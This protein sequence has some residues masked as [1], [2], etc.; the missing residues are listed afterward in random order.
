MP[1]HHGYRYRSTL[2]EIHRIGS[3]IGL[4]DRRR[5]RNFAQA[6]Q[7]QLTLNLSAPEES[8]YPAVSPEL[9]ATWGIGVVEKVTGRQSSCRSNHSADDDSFQSRG[10]DGL[11]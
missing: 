1:L 9:D 6:L 3:D 10:H 11:R 2:S 8:S 5:T 7:S 4:V